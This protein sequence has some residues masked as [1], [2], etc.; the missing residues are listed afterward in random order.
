EIVITTPDTLFNPRVLPNVPLAPIDTLIINDSIAATDSTK[1]VPKNEIESVINYY[2]EDSIV[3][4]FSATKVFLYKDAWFEYGNIRLDAD[5]IE[6]DWEK[7]MIY[8]SGL[9]DTT[10]VKQGNPIFKEGASTYEIRKEMRYNFKSSKAIITD[11]VTQQDEGLLRGETVKKAEDGSIYLSDG[12]YTTCD[13]V[14]PHWHISSNKIKSIRG[15]KIVSGPFNFYFNNIPTPLGLPFGIIPDQPEEQSSG[16]IF[17]SYGEEQAR[18][19]F[20]R[21]FGYYFALNDYIH[22]KITGEVFS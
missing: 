15:E 12:F 4:D 6:I 5:Y 17:P 9:Q 13:L 18:G 2:A 19:F 3:S 22:T 1:A 10:G 7:S 14:V 21:D 20:L 16:I 11:V 8:A